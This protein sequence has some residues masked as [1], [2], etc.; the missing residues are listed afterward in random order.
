MEISENFTLLFL[1]LSILV[2]QDPWAVPFTC[3][4]AFLPFLGKT[5][6]LEGA[7]VG[8]LPSPRWDKML[9]IFSPGEEPFIIKNTLGKFHNSSFPLLLAEPRGYVSCSSS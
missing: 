7:R 6:Q 9:V 1:N 2:G 4:E 8:A 3:F 5:G